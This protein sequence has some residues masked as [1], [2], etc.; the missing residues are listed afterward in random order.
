[1]RLGKRLIA[2]G[3][4][5]MASLSVAGVASADPADSHSVAYEILSFRY[6]AAGGAVAFSTVRQGDVVLKSGGNLSYATTLG[7][8]KVEVTLDANIGDG[9]TLGAQVIGSIAPGNP[10]VAAGTPQFA[11]ATVALRT[12]GEAATETFTLPP[13]ESGSPSE[14]LTAS[15]FTPLPLSL[16]TPQYIITGINNCGVTASPAVASIVYIL[17]TSGSTLSPSGA[18]TALAGGEYESNTEEDST[19]TF[20]LKA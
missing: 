2:G 1:M 15:V 12:G 16:S 9:T 4:V 18:A 20:T 14:T 5:V 11:T 10:C 8:D 7:D 19:V 17:D 6:L 3:L 13:T